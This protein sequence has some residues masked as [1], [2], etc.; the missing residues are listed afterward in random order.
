MAI[1]SVINKFATQAQSF[2]ILLGRTSVLAAGYIV[3]LGGKPKAST[4]IKPL[5]KS[6]MPERGHRGNDKY[7]NDKSITEHNN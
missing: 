3:A 1:V 6:P 4:M 5:K 7:K 2:S